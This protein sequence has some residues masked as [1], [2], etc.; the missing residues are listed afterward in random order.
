MLFAKALQKPE[1][2][3]VIKI[4]WSPPINQVAGS[5]VAE[6]LPVPKNFS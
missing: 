3:F 4:K 5:P 1:R 2:F 6:A